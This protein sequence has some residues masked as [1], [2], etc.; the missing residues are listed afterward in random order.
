MRGETP[1]PIALQIRALA[2]FINKLSRSD[3]EGRLEAHGLAVGALPFSVMQLLARRYQTISELSRAMRLS[4]ATL[5]PAVDALERKGLVK[6]GQDL[7]DRRR[8]PISLTELGKDMLLMVPMVDEKDAL[9][10]SLEGMGQEKGEQLLALLGE[11]ANGMA[12]ENVAGEVAAAFGLPHDL[13]PDEL[14]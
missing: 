5:V 13:K 8:T 12:G 11:L 9:V 7:H 4:P 6:R 10:G 14:H 1:H 3:L 2:G